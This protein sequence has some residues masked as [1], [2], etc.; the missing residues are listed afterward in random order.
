MEPYTKAKRFFRKRC[1]RLLALL[2]SDRGKE[3]RFQ[4]IRGESLKKSLSYHDGII[5]ISA[6]MGVQKISSDH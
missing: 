1:K 6:I 4:F 2:E 5:V 3:D